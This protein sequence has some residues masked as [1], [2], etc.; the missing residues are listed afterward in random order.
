MILV[1]ELENVAGRVSKSFFGGSLWEYVPSMK[2]VLLWC[3]NSPGLDGIMRF[4]VK[5]H[6]FEQFG[7]F[8]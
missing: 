5:K 4:R 2:T 7:F 6:S 3:S 1:A 8:G